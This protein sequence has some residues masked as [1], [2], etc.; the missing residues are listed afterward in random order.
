MTEPFYVAEA[1][2]SKVEGVHRRAAIATGVTFDFGVHGAVKQY[3]RLHDAR[4][5]PLPVDYVVAATAG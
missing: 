5:L 1:H 2:V 3:Y 4:D